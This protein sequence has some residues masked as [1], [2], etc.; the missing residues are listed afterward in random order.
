MH[1]KTQ[2]NIVYMCWTCDKPFTS[3]KKWRNLCLRSRSPD[4]NWSKWNVVKLLLY[5][6]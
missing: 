4:V 1:L 2:N 6:S 3:E 5:L